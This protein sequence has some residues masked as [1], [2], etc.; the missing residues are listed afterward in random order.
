MK[1][2]S[3]RFKNL[4]S[5]KGEWKIDF[6]A[7]PFDD[8]GLF[9]ITGPTGAGK[10]TILD[11]ICLALYH[12]TPRLGVIS[13]SSNELMTRGCAESIAEVEFEV[14]GKGYRAF[15]SQRRSRNKVDGNLQDAIVELSTLRQGNI[16][17]SQLKKKLEI[18]EA[19]TGLNFARFTKSMMLSQGEFAAFLNASAN[20]RAELL[21]ELTGTEIYGL[22]SE[23]VYQEFNQS[24]QKL[25][26]LESNKNGVEILAA[27]QIAA[28][29]AEQ[30]QIK[31]Y[32]TELEIQHQE[33]TTQQL[34]WHEFNKTQQKKQCAID[35]LATANNHKLSNLE[36]LEKLKCS[37]AA[38]LIKDCYQKSV[39]SELQL[40]EKKQQQQVLDSQFNEHSGKLAAITNSKYAAEEQHQQAENALSSLRQVLNDKVIPLDNQ[41][42]QLN[43]KLTDL[44][45]E[46]QNLANE[47]HN[48]NDQIEINQ[49]SITDKQ[50]IIDTC[51]E[52]NSQFSHCEVVA[53][54]LSGWRQQVNHIA[55]LQQEYT[56]L[57]LEI[58]NKI[59]L[60]SSYEPKVNKLKQAIDV[61]INTRLKQQQTLEKTQAQIDSLL[62]DKSELDYRQSLASLQQQQQ[63]I[64]QLAGLSDKFLAQQHELQTIAQQ[65]QDNQQQSA[66]LISQLEILNY[67][68]DNKT[69]HYQDKLKLVAQ[70]HQIIE[71]TQYRQQLQQDFPCPL[72]GSKVHPLITEYADIK[73]DDE[74]AQLEQMAKELDELKG[75]KLTLEFTLTQLTEQLT[76]SQLRSKE[77]SKLKQQLEFEWQHQLTQLHSAEVA[78]VIGDLQGITA[79]KQ[80]I[81]ISIDELQ[82]QLNDLRQLQQ[83]QQQ[84]QQTLFDS[85]SEVKELEHQ[86]L[87]LA[88]TQQYDND[89]VNGLQQDQHDTK[90]KLLANIDE[91]VEQFN[92]LSLNTNNFYLQQTCHQSSSN[93]PQLDIRC[94]TQ[95]LNNLQQQI[96]DWQQNRAALD[97]AQ[98]QLSI[99]AAAKP[100][101]NNNLAASVKKSS[102][103]GY[104]L[105]DYQAQINQNRHERQQLI[106]AKSVDTLLTEHELQVTGALA[107]A[108]VQQ[109]AFATVTQSLAKVEGQRQQID[110][111]IEQIDQQVK[112]HGKQWQI[113]LDNSPY[114]NQQ[115]FLAAL[116]TNEQQTQLR[117][118]K[119]RLDK[120]LDKAQTELNL[121]EQD[122]NILQQQGE[123]AVYFTKSLNDISDEII[124]IKNARNELGLRLGEIK[125]LLE[126][127]ERKSLAL[128]KV[129]TQIEQAKI[130][131]QDLDLLNNLIGSK[132]GDKF[133]RFAQGLTLD[134]LVSLA[135][136]QLDKLQGRYQL[137]RK[138]SGILELEVLDLWQ[139]D[140]SRDTRTLSGGE[141]F[142]VSLSLALA[143]SDLVSF[144]TSI[145]SLFLDE[146]FGTL[147][148]DTLDIA[149]DALDNLNASGK[150]IGVISHVEAMKERIPVQIQ[151]FK[152][153]GLGYSELN[154]KFIFKSKD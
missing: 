146:G 2:L 46:S 43:E 127:N 88:Q 41:Y 33:L 51:T 82:Q 105:S 77:I 114:Q 37:E 95:Y 7:S 44:N 39:D 22:I 5:L 18:T 140:M 98:K 67:D 143:L 29:I 42:S 93:E 145:D 49:Q 92:A 79:Y 52:K 35:N 71:L 86:L 74:Q 78:L 6:T 53:A 15:W 19:V 138:S 119:Q 59:Q 54:K 4:N 38:F 136:R 100:I 20:D 60:K 121:I 115:A 133:R 50:E 72:C 73:I 128:A 70:Q 14:K 30:T 120:A 62:K 26:I 25:A 118:L 58:D 132:N 116:L 113:A 107:R 66:E 97:Q 103:I 17:A 124:S 111:E 69:A 134:H 40:R 135:N 9:A 137:R 130:Q 102:A 85:Q 106:G 141:S 28:L 8:S 94:V 84:Q 96:E 76:S 3:L 153:S 13:K 57:Q 123:L 12:Q 64:W 139:A 45:N 65:Q 48:I 31:D 21:E 1:I 125:H 142:L 24:S 36:E 55:S 83:Q 117:D 150:M 154:D 16:L 61:A 129:L 152:K 81:K 89:L 101:L 56:E 11:A 63:L 99:F 68:Y 75:Q 80:Q 34:W 110:Q 27:E 104:K 23:A 10:T 47:Q 90:Q 151:V 91:Y 32:D 144:K 126:D 148:A 122:L 109:Q 112:L 131:H 87:A 147:D 108:K 149:L